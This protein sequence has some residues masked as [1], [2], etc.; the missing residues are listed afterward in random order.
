MKKLLFIAM[1]IFCG[2][3]E[4]RADRVLASPQAA[5]EF[6]RGVTYVVLTNDNIVLDALMRLTVEKVWKATPYKIVD[7]AT[8]KE[9]RTDPKNSFLLVTKVK[10]SSDKLLRQYLFMSLLQGDSKAAI[11]ID[12]MPEF[13]SI[14]FAGDVTEPNGFLLEA[15][16]LFL[17]KDVEN[18]SNNMF[19]KTLLFSFE[20]RMKAYNQKN[21]ALLKL[22][23]LYVAQSQMEKSVDRNKMTTQFGDKLV[24]TATLEDF[25]EIVSAGNEKA[26]FAIAIYPENTSKG[27]FGYKLVLG[28][29]GTLYYYYRERDAK[30]FKFLPTDFDMWIRAYKQVD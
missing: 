20:D 18:M 19:K 9:L 10:N 21:M 2:A 11:N 16:L 6:Y 3:M 17:Q 22:K 25:E 28:L 24:F 1:A 29:D 30:R 5:E 14:P 23:T 15:V 12:A 26:A 4:S 13:S 27:I 7:E 8:F